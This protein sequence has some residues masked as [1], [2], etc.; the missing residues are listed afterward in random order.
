VL[1]C[2]K[3]A[4]FREAKKVSWEVRAISVT[5]RRADARPSKN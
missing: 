1:V 3:K 4:V 5:R 2:A